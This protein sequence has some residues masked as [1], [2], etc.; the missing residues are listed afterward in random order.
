MQKSKLIK[1]N[2]LL[3]INT[4]DKTLKRVTS[5]R[6]PFRVISSASIYTAPFEEIL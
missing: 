6:V 5:L 4:C 2:I 3:I 1:S